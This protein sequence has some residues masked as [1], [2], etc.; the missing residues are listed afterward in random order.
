[1]VRNL[2]RLHTM[3]AKIILSFLLTAMVAI[4]PIK[5]DSKESKISKKSHEPIY[6]LTSPSSLFRNDSLSEQSLLT[7][8]AP[9]AHAQLDTT[10]YRQVA[11]PPSHSSCT[12]RIPTD[13]KKSLERYFAN[14]F[15]SENSWT[16][17]AKNKGENDNHLGIIL[18]IEKPTTRCE[19]TLAR[20]KGSTSITTS[21][22]GKT[23]HL[24]VNSQTSEFKP[25]VKSQ[26]LLFRNPKEIDTWVGFDTEKN[27]LFTLKRT[28][29]GPI[30]EWAIS[31]E[32]KISFANTPQPPENS[33]FLSV[34]VKY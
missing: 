13:V 5:A 31:V 21:Y 23:L 10:H 6:R 24:T 3:K 28:H 4:T 22:Q 20:K 15:D 14:S 30:A 33:T 26:V 11:P 9:I 1:M 29:Q 16:G 25:S 12:T 17:N 19:V 8:Q 34:S 32:N 18:S 27:L 7:R 2:Q